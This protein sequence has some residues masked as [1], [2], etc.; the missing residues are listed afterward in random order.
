MNTL[1][2]GATA[3]RVGDG[4][5]ASFGTTT[6]LVGGIG[7][8]AGAARTAPLS[9]TGAAPPAPPVDTLPS[10]DERP[11][12]GAAPAEASA[13]ALLPSPSMPS[14]SASTGIG[15]PL[16]F[17]MASICATPPATGKF[18]SAAALSGAS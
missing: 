5:P 13:A 18:A 6:G 14:G 15:D 17:M 3:G 11:S 4:L 16:P 12:A 10:S 9:V 2:E 8:F 7:T 1:P